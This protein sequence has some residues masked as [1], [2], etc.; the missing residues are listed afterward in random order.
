M[1]AALEF[2]AEKAFSGFRLDV[3]FEAEAGIT[4]L[5]GPSGSGKTTVADM[6]AGIRLPDA[7]RI[8]LDGNV[9]LD[10]DA[11]VDL[12]PERR[13]V[14]Y[15]FQ[16]GL[17]FPHMT[18]RRNLLYG[19]AP[20]EGQRFG[21]VSRL[22]DLEALLDR[23]PA[24]LSGGEARRVAIGRAL[25]SA[26]QALVLDEPLTGI[27]PARRQAFFP[28]LER[29]RAE[30]PVPML[31]I[32]HQLEEILRLADRAVLLSEGRVIA[33]G[34]PEELSTNKEALPHFGPA[35]SGTVLPATILDEG[36]AEAGLTALSVAGGHFLTVAHGLVPGS[37]VRLRILARDV[38]VAR[39][40]P[41]D[42]SVL[43]ILPCRVV[44]CLA[45]PDPSEA[46]IVLEL[47]DAGPGSGSDEAA[48]LVARITES[49]RQRLDLAP[50]EEV[51]AMVKAVAVARAFEDGQA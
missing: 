1:T 30:T 6:I 38:A 12:P 37:R 7:G 50:G 29:L 3:A 4:A 47:T 49:S 15:V 26:P 8:V 11:G 2:R 40:R 28:Y 48:R 34:T 21:E 46:D 25:L 16:D 10:T 31:Y 17:L 39:T 35:D 27:D 45:G 51:F 5:F 14:G 9:V 43:N 33:A 41:S 23:Y 32:T 20:E 36:H 42:T 13:H 24:T 44:E 22:L 19:R 18:V